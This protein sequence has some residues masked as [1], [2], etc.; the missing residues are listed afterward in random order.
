MA[1]V[2]FGTVGLGRVEVEMGIDKSQVTGQVEVCLGEMGWGEMVWDWYGME[3]G[4][5][6]V[7]W[8]WDGS[9]WGEGG[10]EQVGVEECWIG[11]GM[12]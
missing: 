7:V 11:L 2:T 1:C 12:G 8:G 5:D 9:G 4:G 10:V 3:L 6:G